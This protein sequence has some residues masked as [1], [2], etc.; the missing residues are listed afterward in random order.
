MLVGPRFSRLLCV[1]PAAVALAFTSLARGAPSSV[2]A[3]RLQDRAIITE[4]MLPGADGASINGPSL[5]RVPPWVERPLGKYYLYFAHHAGKYLR[6]AYADDLKG[7]WRIHDGG[8]QPL[9]AQ[10]VLRGHI[11]SPEVIVDATTRQIFLFYHGGNSAGKK[12]PATDADG[13]EAGQVTAVS[14]STDGLHFRPLDRVV[15]PAYL[16]V[17]THRGQWFALNHSGVLRRAAALGE[18]FVP[19]AK[20]IGDDIIAAVDPVRLGEPGA[21]SRP[22]KGPFRYSIR[23]VGV[24]VHDDQLTVFFSCVGHRPERI[25]CATVELRGP[26]ETWRAASTFEVLR[27]ETEDEGAR[28]PLAYSRGGISLTRVNELRDPAVFRENDSAWLLY[29]I[30]GEHGIGIAALRYAP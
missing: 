13:E 16:R 12:A 20:I 17:F 18:P 28:L 5:L 23:H 11:A 24:D 3:K 6:L 9:A 25:L 2:T 27:P 29:S 21:A 22:T 14:V 26:P 15:G 4:A 8:V 7:P 19:V 30:A 1:L 10:T